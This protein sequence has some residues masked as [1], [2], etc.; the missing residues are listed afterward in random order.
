MIYNWELCHIPVIIMVSS[1][2]LFYRPYRW[3][4]KFSQYITVC[5]PLF[6]LPSLDYWFVEVWFFL[7]IL[8]I[9]YIIYIYIYIYIFRYCILGL[10]LL[11]VSSGLPTHIILMWVRSIWTQLSSFFFGSSRLLPFGSIKA[12]IWFCFCFAGRSFWLRLLLFL[13]RFPSIE[14]SK[15]NSIGILF[16][17]S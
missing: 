8:C 7:Y 13:P 10:L 16:F 14:G 6:L 2:R 15:K 11:L 9:L 5:L 4:P 17:F 3:C 12:S 1:S